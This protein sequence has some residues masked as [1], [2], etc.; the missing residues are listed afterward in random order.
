V[1]VLLDECLPRLPRNDIVGHDV[2][3]VAQM[4]RAGITNGQLLSV[5]EGQFNVLLKVDRGIEYQQNMSGRQIAV[6]VLDAHNKL[7]ALRTLMPTLLQALT[8]IQ[9][10]D[11]THVNP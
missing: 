11:A 6:V 10:G 2:A 4:G 9:P 8:T 5:A 7:P 1:R 3:T